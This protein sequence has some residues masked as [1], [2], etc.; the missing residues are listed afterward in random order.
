V[1]VQLLVAAGNGGTPSVLAASLKVY[2]AQPRR[3]DVP[4]GEAG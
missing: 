1:I 4:L 2:L 3:S